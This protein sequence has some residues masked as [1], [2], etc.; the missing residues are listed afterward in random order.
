MENAMKTFISLML[1]VVVFS[2]GI[3]AD[4]IVSLPGLTGVY[5]PG[6]TST[7]TT[8]AVY[9][10]NMLP[11]SIAGVRLKIRGYVS[12]GL[13]CLVDGGGC[14][15]LWPYIKGE[16]NPSPTCKWSDQVKHQQLSLSL[17]LTLKP[18]G[19][20]CNSFDFLKDGSETISLNV[21]GG[22]IIAIY[23]VIYPCSV[24]VS[25]AELVIKDTLAVTHPVFGEFL[26]AGSNY[27]IIWS[28]IRT[29]GVNGYNLDSSEDSGQTWQSI[30]QAA[31][32]ARSFLWNVPDVDSNSC[33]V[34]V[35]DSN[36]P[37]I[38]DTSNLFYIYRCTNSIDGDINGDCYVNM[39]DFGRI[40]SEWLDN[41]QTPE[42]C[43]GA[44]IDT[45]S[46]VDMEDVRRFCQHWL[47]CINQYDENC[48]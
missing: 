40:A 34:R 11:K 43:H 31:G 26:L 9:D 39:K 24:S 15:N 29:S 41:C 46:K 44:D 47:E 3:A 20:G 23:T 10:P 37:N 13:A 42:W 35:T 5:T 4:F 6:A 48:T 33:M 12:P 14:I 1:L 45:S 2:N 17:E 21:S 36:D 30:G 22:A 28:D 25:S 8:L 27:S 18:S 16:M 32:T 7:R 19:N 38:S